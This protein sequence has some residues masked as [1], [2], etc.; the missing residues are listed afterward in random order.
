GM[1]RG[2]MLFQQ[3]LTYRIQNHLLDLSYNYYRHRPKSVNASEFFGITTQNQQLSLNYRIQAPR[4][5]YNF[6]GH[7]QLDSQDFITFKRTHQMEAARFQAQAQ[8]RL[9]GDRVTL[10][11]VTAAGR[12]L[13]GGIQDPF[14]FR[15]EL[16]LQ[17]GS[18]RLSAS[19][20]YNYHNIYETLLSNPAQKVYEGV[21]L[22][23]G[24][25]HALFAKRMKLNWG[26]NYTETP[27]YAGLQWNSRINWE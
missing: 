27:S 26:I 25:N 5:T 18:V 9:F 14:T 7:Y 6:G 3:K 8:Y 24:G 4:A 23:V 12:L 13:G 19:Y 17:Y 16:L 1:R 15:S 21:G 22:N 20:Q 10:G 2:M 11:A